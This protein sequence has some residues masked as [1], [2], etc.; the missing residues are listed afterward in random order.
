MIDME[1]FD[2]I[3]MGS[4]IIVI[5]REGIDESIYLPYFWHIESSEISLSN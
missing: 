2:T 5:A 4:L 3:D 1:L